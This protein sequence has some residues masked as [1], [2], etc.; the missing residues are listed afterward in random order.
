[1]GGQWP[2]FPLKSFFWFLPETRCL[3]HLTH[4]WDYPQFF[5]PPSL[6][7]KNRGFQFFCHPT[8]LLAI[9]QGVDGVRGCLNIPSH[10]TL[11]CS[12]IDYSILA[13]QRTPAEL[14]PSPR[15]KFGANLRQIWGK[16]WGDAGIG[17][18]TLPISTPGALITMWS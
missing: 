14:C 12:S 16:F 18:Y 1:M 6:E 2:P 17:H 4:W 5:F 11:P 15:C 3:L 7:H 13:L 9:S 8:T 10:L